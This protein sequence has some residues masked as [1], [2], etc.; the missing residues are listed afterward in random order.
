LSKEASRAALSGNKVE[1]VGR[2][3]WRMKHTLL[4]DDRQDNGEIA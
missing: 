1:G 4:A 3:A 2:M